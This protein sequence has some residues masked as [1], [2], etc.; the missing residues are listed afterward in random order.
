MK[1]AALRHAGGDRADP[2]IRRGVKWLLKQIG[3]DYGRIRE[4]VNADVAVQRAMEAQKRKE[5][6]ERVR[7]IKE[8]RERY[9]I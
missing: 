3:Q 4:R 8:E 5:R 9:V 1:C 2:A 7:K 6:S